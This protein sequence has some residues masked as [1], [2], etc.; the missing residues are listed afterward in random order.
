MEQDYGFVLG[1]YTSLFIGKM[2]E[3]PPTPVVE[4]GWL[5]AEAGKTNYMGFWD[6]YSFWEDSY[7][8]YD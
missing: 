2:R 7:I 8:W 5:L 4:D 1:S 3:T 6:D